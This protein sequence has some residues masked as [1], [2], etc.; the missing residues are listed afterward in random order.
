MLV[1]GRLCGLQDACA[2]TNLPHFTPNQLPQ[3]PDP[4]NSTEVCVAHR[5][6]RCQQIWVLLACPKCLS[7]RGDVPVP[8][9]GG[10]GGLWP[11]RELIVAVIDVAL[12]A[13]A[14]TL[15]SWS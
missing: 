5:Y 12:G 8:V 2:I 1:S 3:A 15:S 4:E 14:N 10:E 13:A 7:C 11:G 6:L 9:G